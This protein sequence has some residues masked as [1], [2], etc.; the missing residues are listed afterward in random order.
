[1]RIFAFFLVA[2][3]AACALMMGFCATAN[4]QTGDTG[5]GVLDIF[6]GVINVMVGLWTL[7]NAVEY[8]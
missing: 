3:N 4:F 6:L 8:Y 2:L 5:S 7:N 1:M